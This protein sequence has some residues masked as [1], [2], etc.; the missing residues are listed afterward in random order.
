MAFGCVCSSHVLGWLTSVEV[1]AVVPPGGSCFLSCWV[2]WVLCGPLE[3]WGAGR[4]CHRGI[5]IQAA[6]ASWWH[7]SCS[8]GRKP[9]ARVRMQLKGN[10][11]FWCFQNVRA[12]LRHCA[13][14]NGA[15]CCA[16][17]LR[18][19]LRG[20]GAVSG[21]TETEVR[22]APLGDPKGTNMNPPTNYLHTPFRLRFRGR[23]GGSESLNVTHAHL[24]GCRRRGVLT[25]FQ[26][27]QQSTHNKM[28]SP[29]QTSQPN[30]VVGADLALMVALQR[31]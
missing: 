5:R 21:S 31:R 6:A 13:V 28:P 23:S 27:Q 9:A 16:P 8:G 30:S 20:K 22:T 4:L 14:R 15:A 26:S 1:F 10:R 19:A 24:A 11:H 12:L 29:A 25:P 3:R 2:G 17:R 18:C 7:V